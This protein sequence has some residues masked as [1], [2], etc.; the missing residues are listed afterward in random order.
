MRAVSTTSAPAPA[1]A[2]AVAAPMPLPPPV[3]TAT[4]PSSPKRSLVILRNPEW[5][6]ATA[7]QTPRCAPPQATSG[8]APRGIRH[9][10]CHYLRWPHPT[11][12]SGCARDHPRQRQPAPRSADR[13]GPSTL[14]RTAAGDLLF[15]C[16]RGVLMRAAAAGIG[17]RRAPRLFLTH[18]HSDHITDLND[19]VTIAVGDV[20]R[21]A[22][23]AGRTARSAPSAWCAAPRPCSSPTSA[24]AWPTTTT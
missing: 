19:L 7:C 23:A 14:V 13:A 16:G 15:D 9:C 18:L 20:V 12:G 6:E 24:T 2:T 3:M 5:H 4:L 22:T 21:A 1:K 8:P 10:A 11:S 17:R